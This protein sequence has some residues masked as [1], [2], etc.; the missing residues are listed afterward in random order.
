MKKI[1]VV[2]N[3]DWETDG[4]MGALVNVG[5]HPPGLPFP[6]ELHTPRYSEKTQ[7]PRAVFFLPDKSAPVLRVTV[8]CIQDLMNSGK[9][10]SSSEEKYRVLPPVLRE[11]DP[12]LVI[13]VSTAGYPADFTCN[14][15][16]VIGGNFF[17]HD[18]Y[19]QEPFNPKSNLKNP[20]IGVLLPNNVNPKLY[21][22]IGFDF[23]NGV[24][25]KF[26][27]TPRNP[28]DHPCC[29][30]SDVFTALSVINVTEYQEYNW[31]DHE[32]LAH[33]NAVEKRLPCN[34]SETTHGVVKLCTDKPVVFLSPI[35]D[36]FGRF[37]FEVTPTQNYVASFNAGLVLGHLLCELV[38][39]VESGN[40]FEK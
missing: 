14:G 4:V 1:T 32:A 21:R 12:D 28:G 3:K 6:D 2:V 24:E 23:R 27:K 10:A 7:K 36:Q 37:D 29:I 25:S 33:Y 16:V 30:A 20:G 17:I 11:D 35:T 19:A 13:S 38:G 18:E 8:R 39:F 31:A 9:S 40:T 22:L 5:L 26:L 15:S 34:S